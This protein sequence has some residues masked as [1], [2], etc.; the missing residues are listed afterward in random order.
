M[1]TVEEINAYKRKWYRENKEK[2]KEYREKNKE[3]LYIKSEERR[4]NKRDKCRCGGLKQFN[5]I[6][7]RKCFGKKSYAHL[8]SVDKFVDGK[9]VSKYGIRNRC[10]KERQGEQ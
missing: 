6:T 8:S 10:V 4:K 1:R 7:C 9:Y 2:A 5:A 3:K